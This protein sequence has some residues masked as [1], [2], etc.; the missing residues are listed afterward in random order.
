MGA[1]RSELP[2]FPYA[3]FP[4]IRIDLPGV[5]GHDALSRVSRLVM[6]GLLAAVTSAARA[7][8][9][10]GLAGPLTGKNGMGRSSYQRGAESAVEDLNAKGGVLGQRIG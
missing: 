3:G 10:I 2:G 6:F 7:D 1:I 4:R 8:V 9:L 5:P